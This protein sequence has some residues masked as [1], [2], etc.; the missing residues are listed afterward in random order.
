MVTYL[1]T[2]HTTPAYNTSSSSSS[3]SSSQS[4]NNTSTSTIPAYSNMAAL[5]LSDCHLT[6]LTPLITLFSL[7]HFNTLSY[8]DLSYNPSL[9]GS[10][11]VLLFG[12]LASH[13]IAVPLTHLVVK[14]VGLT[15]AYGLM[16]R[17]LIVNSKVRH[18][19]LCIHI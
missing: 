19:T 10:D 17:N 15:N 4:R 6:S 14:S 13:T 9:K 11:I 12:V 3:S 16:V 7:P 2:I 1:T 5:L 18:C 8:L